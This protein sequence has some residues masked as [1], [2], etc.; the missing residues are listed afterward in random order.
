MKLTVGILQNKVAWFSGFSG[1]F[2]QRFG[3]KLKLFALG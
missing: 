2:V 3:R 1:E